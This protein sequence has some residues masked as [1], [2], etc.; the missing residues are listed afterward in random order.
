ME[1]HTLTSVFQVF[2]D[3]YHFRHRTVVKRSLSDHRG[4]QIRLEK[5][6]KVRLAATLYG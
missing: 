3:Y 1:V 5:D 6:P 2:G 4:T